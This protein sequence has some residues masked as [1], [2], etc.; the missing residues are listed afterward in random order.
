MKAKTQWLLAVAITL[1]AQAASAKGS[2]SADLSITNTTVP[3]PATVRKNLTCGMNV[4]NHGPDGA[5]NVQVTD[6]L[7]TGV[8]LS[9][10]TFNFPGGTP[11]PCSGTTAIVCDIG[12]LGS[13]EGV[14]VI[15]VVLPQQVTNV[16]SN[17]ATVGATEPDP[18][19]SNNT[20]TPQTPLVAQNPNPLLQE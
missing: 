3:R 8:T 12:S 2:P 10:A 17:T 14:A 16:L 19:P 20:A 15:I 18:D 6:T 9:S 11:M 4:I 5:M 7:P 13:S 1:S